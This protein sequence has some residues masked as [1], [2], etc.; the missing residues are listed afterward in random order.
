MTAQ[1]QSGI[2]SGQGRQPYAQN[3]SSF[4][5]QKAQS[6]VNKLQRRIYGLTQRKEF[7]KVT[8]TQKLLVKS[9]SA[10]YLAVR[11]VTSNKGKF[12]AGVDG[13]VIVSAEEKWALMEELKDF[14]SYKPKPT[15]TVFIPKKDGT[16][17]KLGIPTI[18]DR[19]MQALLL[20]ALEPEWEAKF[21]PHSFGFRPGRSAIDAVQYIGRAFVPKKG[22]RPHPGWVLDADMSACFDNICHDALLNKLEGFPFRRIIRDWLKAGSVSRIGFRISEKGTPQGG[23]ISPLLANIALDGME[24]LFGIHSRNGNYL[25]PRSRSKQNKGI[26]LY[27]YADDFIVLAP[28]RTILEEYILPT[29]RKFLTNV[30]ISFNDAKTRIVNITEGFDFLGFHFRRFTRRDGSIKEFIYSPVRKRIDR[31]LRELHIWIR[32]RQSRSV[33]EIIKGLNRRIRGFCNYFK[34]SNA[35]KSFAYM[36]HRIYKLMW[37]WVRHRHQRKRGARWL[38]YRY[39]RPVKGGRSQWIFHFNGVALAQPYRFTV[40]WWRRPA[41]RIHTS[42]YDPASLNYWKNR[43]KRHKWALGI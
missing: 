25:N 8:R 34:W 42:P 19:A 16:K 4:D 12:T 6:E 29:I 15:R 10:R 27:R 2:H 9:A 41:V 23:V 3:W 7:H 37:N 24:R 26:S 40:K 38:K 13:V 5:H 33:K 36:T 35:H 32:Q 17:R 39:W 1:L 22:R 11:R 18:K 20:I 43:A 21:E 14:K 31:F 30:G 28:N